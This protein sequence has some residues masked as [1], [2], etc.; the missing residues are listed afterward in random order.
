MSQCVPQTAN[1]S[2]CSSNEISFNDTCQLL[3][4]ELGPDKRLEVDTFGNNAGYSCI[5]EEYVT[6][7]DGTC[8]PLL[9]PSVVCSPGQQIRWS[10]LS[11]VKKTRSFVQQH[12]T[13]LDLLRKTIQ[14]SG[15][16]VPLARRS[17]L[18]AIVPQ[19]SNKVSG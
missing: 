4:E 12:S 14:L 16:Q 6:W 1:G 9:S 17:V 19:V 10:V 7:S 2:R 5:R 18:A 13:N 11:L 15:L 8:Y 3:Y